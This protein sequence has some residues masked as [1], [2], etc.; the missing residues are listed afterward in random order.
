MN[1]EQL[2]ADYDYYRY[3]T[4]NFIAASG[5]GQ[6]MRSLKRTPEREE[7]FERFAAFCEANQLNP[8]LYLYSLFDARQWT[9]APRLDQLVPGTKK[10]AKK[11]IARFHALKEVPLYA[12]RMQQERDQRGDTP[13]FD[14]NKDISGTVENVKRRYVSLYQFERCMS[15][16]NTV[17]LGYHPKSTVCLRCPT[18]TECEGL[19]QNMVP[20][21]IVALRRG[22]LSADEA[23]RIAGTRHGPR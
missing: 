22:D 1:A 20:F 2:F 16:I 4:A 19:T 15:E 6:Y 9:F 3:H 17:T 14:P 7:Q 10:T 21:D 23:K 12:Q 5:R 8:R 18:A 13:T 11:A